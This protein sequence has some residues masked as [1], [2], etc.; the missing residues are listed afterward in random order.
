VN[1]ELC[2]DAVKSDWNDDRLEGERDQ[3]GHVEIA[4]VPYV[5]LP[6][7]GESQHH[8]LQ[9]EDVQQRIKAVLIKQHEAD[10]HQTARQEMGDVEGEALH[11]R[12]LVTN[13]S[14][15]PRKPSIR[16][17]PTKSGARKTRI[18]AMLVSNTP[19]ATPATAS[20][21]R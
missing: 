8:R 11:F 17:A 4:G 10:Q 2:D 16:A 5:S 19:S 1:A 9:C 3:G 13:N 7:H 15:A 14:N 21:A 6:G 18:L 12:V 20:L